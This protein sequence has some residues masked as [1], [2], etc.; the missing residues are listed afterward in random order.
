MRYYLQTPASVVCCTSWRLVTRPSV[1]R[2]TACQLFSSVVC[3]KF[4]VQLLWSVWVVLVCWLVLLHLLL[5]HT[6]TLSVCL[7]LLALIKGLHI[8]PLLF[9]LWSCVISTL[10][11][12]AYISRWHSDSNPCVWLLAVVGR[13]TNTNTHTH[14]RFLQCNTLI[15]LFWNAG[16]CDGNLSCVCERCVHFSKSLFVRSRVALYPQLFISLFPW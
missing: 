11:V 1:M 2:M 9:P 12:C 6:E 5:T 15:W 7:W 16:G 3:L 13:H 14:T 10:S 8:R 4:R